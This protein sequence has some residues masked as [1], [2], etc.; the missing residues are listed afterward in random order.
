MCDE[1]EYVT[2]RDSATGQTPTNV[3]VS[4][5]SC[6]NISK[7]SHFSFSA[8]SV[9]SLIPEHV[10]SYTTRSLV[11]PSSLI[12]AGVEQNMKGTQH[13]AMQINERGTLFDCKGL[14]E[15][16]TVE[17]LLH[18]YVGCKADRFGHST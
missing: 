2:C 14:R 9:A 3:C 15:A 12:P 11:E 7:V 13:A 1:H 4:K 18:E 5:I 17:V 10:R 8:G 16:A 6:T